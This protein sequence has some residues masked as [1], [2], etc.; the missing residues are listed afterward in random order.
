MHMRPFLA[1]RLSLTP[2]LKITRRSMRPVTFAR[3]Y[4]WFSRDSLQDELAIGDEDR[5]DSPSDPSPECTVWF[6]K[7]NSGIHTQILRK[8]VNFFQKNSWTI[9]GLWPD[10]CDGS[11]TQYCD[12]SRQFN[13]APSPNT[14]NSLPDSTV[15]PPYHGPGVDTFIVDFGRFDLLDYTSIAHEFSKHATST[16]TFGI[17]CYANYKEHE[18]VI[19]FF[20]AVVC[21]FHMFLTYNMLAGWC[22]FLKQDNILNEMW[23]FS[24][25]IG[26]EQYGRFKPVDSTI[27]L[28]CSEQGIHYLERTPTLQWDVRVDP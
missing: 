18:D 9:H 26:T 19:N 24:H 10:F 3:D 5:H 14:T 27:A 12:L 2:T 15:V 11:F 28:M 1:G 7:L 8:K 4:K 6:Y 17:A 21:A 16:S 13:P 20:D 23:H 22:H 25:V